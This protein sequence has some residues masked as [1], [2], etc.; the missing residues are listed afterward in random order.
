M[1]NIFFFIFLL[2]FNPNITLVDILTPSPDI[3]PEKVI[4]IQLSALM[5][6]N[7]PY[8]N[9][10]IEQTWEFAHPSN[11]LFT[12]PLSNFTNM[13]YS[14][15]YFKMLNH[16]E[17]KIILV[18]K[19]KDES[20]FFIEIIDQIGNKYGF[21]WTVK[22]VLEKGRYNNCWM[23]IGVSQPMPLGNSA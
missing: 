19:T 21:Q 20:Y 5:K 3:D 14:K 18:K 11:K 22:K 15:S 9:A 16:Q 7:I 10:G 2:F 13:M 8:K 12:G 4:S 17:H 6:N 23:T 1:K